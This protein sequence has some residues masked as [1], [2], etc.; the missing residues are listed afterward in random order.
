MNSETPIT[1]TIDGIRTSAQRG[2]TIMDAADALGIR[3][4]RL[5][6][7]P[8]LSILGACRVCLVEVE[9]QRN[10]VASC[11]FPVAEGMV[12]RTHSA[13]LRRLRR[14]VVELIL[15]NH[16]KDCQT[17]ERDGNCE[18]QRLAYELGIRERLYEGERKNMEKDWSSPSV[19]RDPEK[20]ILC[21]RCVR[22]CAEVQGVFNLSQHSRGFHIDVGPAHR[23]TMLDSVCVHCGQC[24]N[25]CPTASII[26]SNETERVFAALENPDL[27]VVVQT[28]PSI[29]AAV[30]EGFGFE[31]GT[32]ATGKMVTALRYMGFAR[33]FDTNF[34]ADLT[35]VEEAHEFLAR[36]ENDE[37]LPLITSCS[38]GW[39]NFM[40][41]FYPDLIPYASS[42]RSPMTMLSVLLKTYYAEKSGIDPASI[43][44]VAVMPCTAKKYEA[45][46]PEHEMENGG[47]Y[48][49]AVLTTR[50]IIWMMK[51]LGVNFPGLGESD[52]D[53]PLGM[54]SGAADI[55][56]TTGGVMEAALRTACEKL[57]G[58]KCPDLDYRQVRGVE[59]FKEAAV[60]IGGRTL[61]VGVSNGLTNAKAMLDK[62]M[63]NPGYFHM[64][65]VMA[66][67]GGCIGGGGQP[68]PPPG[69]KILD[70]ELLKKRAEALY[71]ID[72]DKRL[73]T[74][75]DNPFIRKLYE[76]FLGEPNGHRAHE[77]LHTHYSPKL[78]R[79]V[80]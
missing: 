65:E 35:I 70:R 47:A 58:R 40:E 36:L 66:C 33:V 39:I 73:R 69:T 9:G 19:V 54:S 60:E 6:Y 22:V 5:C 45:K 74:S 25:V 11:A 23:G 18:L 57:T 64:C 17:C 63:A 53:V 42:C 21:G 44:V 59:G 46:R 29:R 34:G 28:A 10:P 1:L 27:H 31:P 3:I 49:D 61:R 24:A 15:D 78:P 7:H 52:F 51:S 67:P 76:E 13:L 56:G 68:Y 20:C 80:R 38:P 79:G 41:H 8:D 30:G 43:F 72:S 71:T 37:K 4:P 55:F 77:L 26:E 14:D 75:H 62:V 50:E 12:V 48:T 32:P 16:P 2:A